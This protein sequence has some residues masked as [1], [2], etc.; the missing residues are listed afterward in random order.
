MDLKKYN[1]TCPHCKQILNEG[2]EIELVTKRNHGDN[3][4]IYLSVAFGNYTYK[5]IPDT[6]FQKGELVEFHCPKCGSNLASKIYENFASLNMQVDTN[7][8]FEVIFS[9]IAGERKTYVVTED[10]IETYQG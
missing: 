3:G 5:H 10:G 2:D 7:I 4:R 1:F 6:D 9:R 8:N